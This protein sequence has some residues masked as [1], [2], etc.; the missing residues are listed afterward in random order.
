MI[1][2]TYIYWLDYKI[3][4]PHLQNQSDFITNYY[5]YL[6]TWLQNSDSHY[7]TRVTSLQTI[8]SIYWLWLQTLTNGLGY[9]IVIPNTS[10][11]WLH[12]KLLQKIFTDF[13][14]KT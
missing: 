7:K 13:D 8:T 1:S 9:K 6:L 12:Y 11:Y 10:I 14:Y 4:I 2:I 5:K 3:V